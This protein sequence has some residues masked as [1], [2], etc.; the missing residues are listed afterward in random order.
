MVAKGYSQM[1]GID[2]DEI[3]SPVARLETIRVVLALAA[4]AGWNVFH[5]DVKSAFL[6]GDIQEEVF[7]AQPERYI[8]EGEEHRV[9][10]LKKAL[11]GLKQALRA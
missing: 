8:I 6:N 5:F 9:Y 1:P 3:F 11:Y 4:H 10:K 7:V 2:Y